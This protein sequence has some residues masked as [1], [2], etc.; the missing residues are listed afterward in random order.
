MF[1][2]LVTDW[3]VIEDDY[4]AWEEASALNA[5]IMMELFMEGLGENIL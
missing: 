2:T 5:E 3:E 4:I 1:S